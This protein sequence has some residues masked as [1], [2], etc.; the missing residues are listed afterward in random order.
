MSGFVS[1]GPDAGGWSC[2][3]FSI[4]TELAVATRVLCSV[5][6]RAGIPSGVRRAGKSR[7][8][9]DP[10]ESNPLKMTAPPQEGAR[11][12]VAVPGRPRAEHVYD[13]RR[14]NRSSDDFYVEAARLSDEVLAAVERRAG[15]LLDGYGRHVHGFLAEAPRSRGE[16]A[17]ELLSLGMMLR[18][19]EGAAQATSEWVVELAR[20]MAW[21]RERKEE[22]KPLVDWVR[23]GIARL[24]L[25]PN[26]GKKPKRHGSAVGRLALLIDWLAAT[27]E[28]KQESMRLNNWRSYMAELKPDKAT[29]WLQVADELFERFERD[30]QKAL[31]A[32]TRGVESFVEQEQTGWKWREDLLLRLRPPVEYHLNMVAAELMNRGLREEFERTENRIVLVPTCMR[33]AHSRDCKAHVHGLDITCSGCDPECAVN[34]I[35]QELRA[36]GATV[37]M[38]PHASGLSKWLRRWEATNTGITAVACMLHILPGGFEMRDR[39][40]A[41]QCVPLDYPGCSKHW[42][43]VGIPTSVNEDRLTQIAVGTTHS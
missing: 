14:G 26:L 18:R 3:A 2:D 10:G 11:L 34:R 17:I 8:M 36:R 25:T 13:L 16:Y 27:G 29:H 24:S 19:Y 21:A 12:Q 32:Y 28:F 4:L 22:A 1:K 43:R 20:E 33:G 31:G 6:S 41:S 40:I 42:E 30:S 5:A 7:G 23:A 38:V 35:S 39:R 9:Q 37:Y 15:A